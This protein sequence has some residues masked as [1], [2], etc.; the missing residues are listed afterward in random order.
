MLLT[1][2]RV[3]SSLFLP[4]T[5]PVDEPFHVNHALDVELAAAGQGE[6]GRHVLERFGTQPSFAVF[7]VFYGLS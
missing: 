6:E 4:G 7:V 5:D 2:A 3:L 1:C